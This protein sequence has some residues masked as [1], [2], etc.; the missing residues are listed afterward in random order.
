ML[1]TARLRAMV[2]AMGRQ[3]PL[4]AAAATVVAV[5]TVVVVARKMMLMAADLTELAVLLAAAAAAAAVAAAAAA[6]AVAAAVTAG[7][8]ICSLRLQKITMQISML[9]MMVLATAT[10]LHQRSWIRR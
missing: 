5:A 3:A 4:A 9:T 10:A 6:A 8:W 2:M 7:M 1:T